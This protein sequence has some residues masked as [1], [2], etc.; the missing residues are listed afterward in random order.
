MDDKFVKY[1]IVLTAVCALVTTMTVV[2]FV[3]NH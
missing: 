1:S 2:T 3:L